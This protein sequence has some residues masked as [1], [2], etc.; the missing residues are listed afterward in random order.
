MASFPFSSVLITGANRGLGL[1]MVKH[2]LNSS[3]VPKHIIATCRSLKAENA[4]ELQKLAEK[5][6]NIHVLEM[7]MADVS[8][9]RL[10]ELV[11]QVSDIVQESGLNLL[12]NNAGMNT[13]D[14]FD[15][16]SADSLRSTFDVNTVAPFLI[17]RAFRPLLK[18][19]AEIK[20]SSEQPEAA[21]VNISSIMGSIC[22]CTSGNQ[23][24][25][26]VSKTALNMVT[27]AVSGEF[28]GDSITV[29]SVH[30]GWVKTDMG[31]SSAPLSVDESVASV[32]KVIS[33]LQ[34]S[35]TG[36]FFRYDG[37]ILPW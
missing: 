4:L 7:D 29:V 20:E 11:K 12:V 37:T 27:K 34:K 1:N 30:P 28:A 21:V 22:N 36:S 5:H 15:E 10:P 25:Y 17:T 19:A 32:I 2:I 3:T 14:I 13:K 31:G 35:H 33:S 16:V 9:P 24:A 18:R 26:K 23:L 8:G 6:S